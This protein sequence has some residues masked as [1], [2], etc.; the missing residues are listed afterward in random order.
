MSF[1]KTRMSLR[2]VIG[3]DYMIRYRLMHLPH[4]LRH[5][6]RNENK[7]EPNKCHM[8]ETSRRFYRRKLSRRNSWRLPICCEGRGVQAVVRCRTLAAPCHLQLDQPLLKLLYRKPT[9]VSILSTSLHHYIA[10]HVQGGRTSTRSD[11]AL[12]TW[13]GDV[14]LD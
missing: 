7:M 10:R 5:E 12:G 3:F 14:D 4:V 1:R 8:N 11:F 6:E 2:R 13:S 9:T